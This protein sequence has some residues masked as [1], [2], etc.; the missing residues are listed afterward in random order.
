MTHGWI[1]PEQLP[2]LGEWDGPIYG[3]LGVLVTDGIRLE[4][5]ACGRWFV[6]LA[7][8]VLKTHGLLPAEYRAIFGLRA[9]HGLFGPR[10]RAQ[11]AEMAVRNFQP[12]WSEAGSLGKARAP[13][14]NAAYLRGRRLRL[15][16]K[17]DPHNQQ[18]RAEQ[19]A[20][21]QQVGRERRAAGKWSHQPP[22][23]HAP[24]EKAQARWR[25]LMQDPDYRRQYGDKRSATSMR[26]EFACRKCGATFTH[27]RGRQRLRGYCGECAA[28]L[29]RNRSGPDTA[30]GHVS[31]AYRAMVARLRSLDA[32]AFAVLPYED[33]TLV[34]RAYGLLNEEPVPQRQLVA[35]SGH[36]HYQI[37]QVLARSVAILLGELPSMKRGLAICRGCGR[38]FPPIKGARCCS[39]ACAQRVRR[40]NGRPDLAALRGLDTQ[41]FS[42]LPAL[43]RSAVRLYYGLDSG[44]PMTDDEVAVALSIGPTRARELVTG[45]VAQLLGQPRPAG[46]PWQRKIP[47]T[48]VC[49]HCGRT[50]ST[51]ARRQ[52]YCSH[53][54]MVQIRRQRLRPELDTLQHLDADAF[55]VLTPIERAAIL[56]YYGLDG[57]EPMGQKQVA[58]AMH[59]GHGTVRT[60]LHEAL[61][62]LL[63]SA[64]HQP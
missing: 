14:Q 12:Y 55:A 53:Q 29:E 3:E 7:Q 58:R 39:R 61:A 9:T 56:M 52:R 21:M 49:P 20:H 35:E 32:A 41:A 42:T 30:G 15:E 34:Q 60:V 19:L 18:L 5:H 17:L 40:R 33:L 2:A 44:E 64:I 62:K 63:P 43:D 27:E 54:C 51:T 47:M 26:K 10:Y 11:M 36:T 8:H 1:P 59:I 6:N 28:E 38:M 48:A 23:W 50:F 22:D 24:L 13:E 37:K 31:S 25:E 46:S 4:C 57:N 16:S 45:A